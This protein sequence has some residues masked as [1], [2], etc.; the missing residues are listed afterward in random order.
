MY[1]PNGAGRAPWAGVL[2][3]TAGAAGDEED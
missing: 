3:H 1:V 2:A